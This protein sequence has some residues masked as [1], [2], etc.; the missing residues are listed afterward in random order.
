MNRKSMFREYK[1]T[2]DVFDIQVYRKKCMEGTESRDRRWSLEWILLNT[3]NNRKPCF[4]Q[5][6]IRKAVCIGLERQEWKSNKMDSKRGRD[7]NDASMKKWRRSSIKIIASSWPIIITVHNQ[8]SQEPSRY[9]W[10]LSCPERQHLNF[11][12]QKIMLL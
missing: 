10:L 1:T 7:R 2:A 3:L 4:F 5:S 11:Y 9:R 8:S 6:V 12:M